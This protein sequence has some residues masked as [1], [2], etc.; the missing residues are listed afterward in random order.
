MTVN[1]AAQLLG[2]LGGKAGR[3]KSKARKITS[4]HARKAVNARWKKYRARK[5]ML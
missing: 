1:R 2:R 5:A 4:E 3:G